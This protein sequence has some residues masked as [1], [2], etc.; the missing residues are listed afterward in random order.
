MRRPLFEYYSELDIDNRLSMI[1]HQPV[2]SHARLIKSSEESSKSFRFDDAVRK[3]PA[4]CEPAILRITTSKGTELNKLVWMASIFPG[5][6]EKVSSSWFS[7]NTG[8][9]FYSCIH[10]GI[11]VGVRGFRKK[12]GQVIVDASA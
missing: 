5:T 8:C 2:S 6:K 3:N 12:T 9:S 10:S 1:L 7:L 11:D 4:I